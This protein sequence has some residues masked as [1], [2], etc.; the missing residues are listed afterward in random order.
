MANQDQPGGESLGIIIDRLSRIARSLQFI[1]GLNP[2]QWEALRFLARANRYSR[3]PTALASYLGTTKG[4]VSQTLISLENKG[5][6][7]RRPERNDRRSLRLEMTPS[8]EDL[9]AKD[10]ILKI[11]AAARRLTPESQTVVTAALNTLF[12][13]LGEWQGAGTFGVCFSCCHYCTHSADDKDGE[14]HYC[15]LTDE[16]LPLSESE[17]ICVRYGEAVD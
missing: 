6:I 9:L 1:C 2:A 4:T 7:A 13:E 3:N 17:K 10:P 12:D 5:Y 11:D 8:G 16:P 14:T 15:A